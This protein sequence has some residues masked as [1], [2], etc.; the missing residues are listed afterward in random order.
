M[1]G[2]APRALPQTTKT[3]SKHNQNHQNHPK[4]ANLMEIEGN[5]TEYPSG[6]LPKTTK[7]TYTSKSDGNQ[8]NHQKPPNLIDIK[9]G[10]V[11]DAPPTK[12]HQTPLSENS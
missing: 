6:A 5:G 10:M 8:Q 7:T 12:N 4:R 9:K 1:M 2:D 11:G 3:L